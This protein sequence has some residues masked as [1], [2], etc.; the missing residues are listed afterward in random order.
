MRCLGVMGH[1]Q[2]LT[3]Q[4]AS[5]G[6][7]NRGSKVEAR[8]PAEAHTGLAVV[9]R[10]KLIFPRGVD[11]GPYFDRAASQRGNQGFGHYSDRTILRSIGTNVPSLVDAIGRH[12]KTFRK[13]QIGTQRLEYMLP[14][15][16]GVRVT[17]ANGGTVAQAATHNVRHLAVLVP[18]ATPNY[19]ASPRRG[20]AGGMS[21]WKKLWR[22]D[23]AT[24]SQ[25]PLLAL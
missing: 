25:Q 8:S 24:I 17:E 22:M 19:I 13:Q 2:C 1:A 15:A 18:V 7:S 11:L 16:H 9:R 4:A 3:A 20:D 5:C 21:P 14:W 6:W 10:Q 23:V 12:A